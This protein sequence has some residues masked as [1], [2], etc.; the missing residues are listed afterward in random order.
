MLQQLRD[1]LGI[2]DVGLAPWKRFDMLSVNHQQFHL[3]FQNVVD[4]L[5][6][7][8]GALHGYMRAPRRHQPVRQ[9]QQLLCEGGKASYFLM[10]FAVGV[11]SPQ[12]RHDKSLVNVDPTAALIKNVHL[13]PPLRQVIPTSAERHPLEKESPTRASPKEEQ[14]SVVPEDAPI[15]LLSGLVAPSTNRSVSPDLRSQN[16]SFSCSVVL[17]PSM[18]GS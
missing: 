12:T 6:E 8:P 4:R 9:P 14:H 1:P 15:R 7:H 13:W 5:P 3:P 17:G 10:Q 18:A 16:I 11:D 2:L